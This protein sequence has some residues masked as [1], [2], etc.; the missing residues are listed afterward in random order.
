MTKEEY[1]QAQPLLNHISDVIS[2]FEGYESL[3]V[4]IPPKNTEKENNTFST[5]T[6]LFSKKGVEIQGVIVKPENLYFNVSKDKQ[7]IRLDFVDATHTTHTLR[8]ANDTIKGVAYPNMSEIFKPENEDK[9]AFNFIVDIGYQFKDVEDV[10][11]EDSLVILLED[12]TVLL[13]HNEE[14]VGN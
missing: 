9:L 11:I 13:F 2:V 10:E 3:V 1:F 7:G 14:N 5:I 12:N 8:L 4:I 6:G